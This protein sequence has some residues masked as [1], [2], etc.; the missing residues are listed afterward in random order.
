[1]DRK[2]LALGLAIALAPFARLAMRAI[3][4]MIALAIAPAIPPSWRAALYRKR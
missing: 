3:V 1:M 4:R 2:L